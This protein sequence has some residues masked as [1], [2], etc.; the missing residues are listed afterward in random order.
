MSDQQTEAAITINGVDSKN[1]TIIGG[2]SRVNH[3]N[4]QLEVVIRFLP[5]HLRLSQSKADD[6]AWEIRLNDKKPYSAVAESVNFLENSGSF[7]LG[8]EF[9]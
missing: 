8:F 9:N 1:Y 7:I 2:N 4:I 3:P 5:E 6:I